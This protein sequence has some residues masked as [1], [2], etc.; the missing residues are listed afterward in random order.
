VSTPRIAI[1]GAGHLGKLH[2]KLL[3]SLSRPSLVAIVDPDEHARE[4]LAE[5]YGIR[6]VGKVED[7]LR[8]IDAAIIAAPSPLHFDLALKCLRNGID[9]LVE[10]PLAIKGD[11]AQTLHEQAQR[12]GRILQV[13]HIERFNPAFVAAQS[14]IS[15]PRYIETKRLGGY[16]FRSMDTGVVMDLMIHDLDLVL[17]LAASPV[18]QVQAVGSTVLGPYEDVAHA[19]IVFENGCRAHLSASRIHPDSIRTLDCLSDD[20]TLHIDF[21]DRTSELISP[22]TQLQLGGFNL[23]SPSPM[24]IAL[25]K[26]QFFESLLVRERLNPPLLDPLTEELRD[27][28]DC[29]DTRRKP[30]VSGADG[31]RAVMLAERITRQIH[32]AASER[33]SE[34]RRAA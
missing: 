28:L 19:D 24:E 30:R 18:S 2:A 13:G 11:D 26:S 34:S 9:L 27:F 3:A 17:Q 23:S 14:R 15:T 8:D 29:I 6:A 20:G 31:V 25:W 12:R 16:S 4:T 5:I 10:K 7:V 32:D 33:S 21:A 22:S 1:V